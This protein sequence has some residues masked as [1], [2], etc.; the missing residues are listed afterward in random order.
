MGNAGQEDQ[1]EKGGLT[2]S[3]IG[4]LQLNNLTFKL[5]PDLAVV[6][7]RNTQSSFFLSQSYSPGG[8][9]TAVVNSGSAF[10]NLRQSVLILDVLN[11]STGDVWFGNHGGSAANFISRIQIIAKNGVVLERIDNANQLAACKVNHQFS[12]SWQV[13]V[14]SLCGILAKNAMGNQQGGWDTGTTMRFV[15]PLYLFSTLCDTMGSLCPAQLLSGARFEILL[16]PAAS[17]LLGTA[18][19][20]TLNYSITQC[21]LE[22]ESYLLTDSVMKVINQVAATQGL[23]VVAATCQNTQS[24]RLSSQVVVDVAKSCSRALN[25]LYKERMSPGA[26][27]VGNGMGDGALFDNVASASIYGTDASNTFTNLPKE[28]QVRAGQ[29]YFP[30]SSIRSVLTN[31]VNQADVEL[32]MQTLRSFQKLNPGSNGMYA[33]TD[34]S[35]TD[36][37][38]VVYEGAY[39]GPAVIT[40]GAQGLAGSDAC[41]ALDLQRSAI[42]TSGIPLSNSHQLSINYSATTRNAVAV[43]IT[44][45]TTNFL[46]DVFLTYQVCIRTFLSQCVLEV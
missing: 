38:G 34:S 26:A 14:G 39:A 2:P 20:D 27:A 6:V 37:R 17:C 22:L 36:F 42:L 15:I 40:A 29:L 19:S 28:W 46:I 18:A 4:I 16:A 12:K 9:M 45:G 8:T 43:G 33:G 32:Y 1:G 13:S 21:R 23:E 30:Q 10:V 25:V 11:S 35:L 5:E 44:S 24:N 31:Q 7:Q 3:Q 41:F